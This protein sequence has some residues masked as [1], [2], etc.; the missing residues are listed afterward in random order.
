MHPRE[1]FDKNKITD[2]VYSSGIIKRHNIVNKTIDKTIIEDY[3][4]NYEKGKFNFQNKSINDFAKYFASSKILDNTLT[5]KNTK[6][7]LKREIGNLVETDRISLT[8]LKKGIKSTVTNEAFVCNKKD[9]S[10]LLYLLNY[11]FSK[12]EQLNLPVKRYNNSYRID[13]LSELQYKKIKNPEAMLSVLKYYSAIKGKDISYGLKHIP[14]RGKPVYVPFTI[15]YDDNKADGIFYI[16]Q[17]RPLSVKNLLSI[18]K[19][20]EKT[21]LSGVKIIANKIGLPAKKFIER[22]N[23][24]AN[25]RIIYELIQFDTLMKEKNIS[26]IL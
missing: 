11:N 20:A 24:E 2:E 1:R 9:T 12:A 13:I 6:L 17:N 15:E 22:I 16:D 3:S 5:Y 8:K 7:E 18:E 10:Q 25:Q 26:R 14:K 19:V 21:N 23:S 4:N